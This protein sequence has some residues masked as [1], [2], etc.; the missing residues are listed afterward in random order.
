MTSIKHEWRKKEKHFYVPKSEPE[1]VI[2]PK[3]NFIIA[4]GEGSPYTDH[5]ANCI[6]ALYAMSYA[7]KMTLKKNEVKPDGYVDYTVYP[8]EGIYDLNEEAKKNF[9]GKI[10]KDDF[11]YQLMIRQPDFVDA[12][13]Y[14]KI[15]EATKKKKPEIP[16]EALRFEKITEGDCVQMLHIGSFDSEPQSF[17]EMEEF[18]R[19]KNRGR[20]SKIHREIY[21]ND[22]RKVSPDK[23]KTV[24][25]FSI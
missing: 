18:A 9:T 17:D 12:R 7:I 3:F 13:Y 23:L 5:F 1:I 14:F 15:L 11:V 6:T 8:L 22:F 25:R 24:L 20:T 21:L 16:L 2:I 4:E 19:L 10:N